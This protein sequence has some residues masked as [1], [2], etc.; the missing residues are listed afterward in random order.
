VAFAGSLLLRPARLLAPCADRTGDAPALGDFYFQ[1]FNGSVT[2]PVAGYS[3]RDSHPLGWQLASL[4]GQILP[5]FQTLGCA[6][7]GHRSGV[8]RVI[9]KLATPAAGARCRPLCFRDALM[10]QSRAGCHRGRGGRSRQ[11]DRRRR[12]PPRINPAGRCAPTTAPAN[13]FRN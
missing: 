9:V 8:A 1:A 12:S 2:L 6:D 3:W 13:K 5:T 10:K 11:R 4:Y 7:C